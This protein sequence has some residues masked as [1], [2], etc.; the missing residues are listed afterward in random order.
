MICNIIRCDRCGCSTE[1]D[2]KRPKW[3]FVNLT[4]GKEGTGDNR[5]IELNLCPE[6]DS[7]DAVRKTI[8]SVIMKEESSL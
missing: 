3:T 5:F 1:F 7:A 8:S 6:C 4:I 2:K